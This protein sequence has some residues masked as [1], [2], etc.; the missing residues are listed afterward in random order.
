[1]I[2]VKNL[3][4]SNTTPISK[5]VINALINSQKKKSETEALC[6]ARE[7]RMRLVISKM[8]ENMPKIDTISNN[9]STLNS[10]DGT[11]NNDLISNDDVENEMGLSFDDAALMNEELDSTQTI[12]KTIR[13]FF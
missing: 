8:T 11:K 13:V 3:V 12:N 4:I 2:F 6:K 7:R 10:T 9:Q 5:K 1:M